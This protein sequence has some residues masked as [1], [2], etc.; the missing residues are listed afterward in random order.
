MPP[1]HT[2][3]DPFVTTTTN[4]GLRT[5]PSTTSLRST[6]SAASTSHSRTRQPQRDQ[7]FAPSLSRRPTSRTRVEDEVLADSSSEHERRSRRPRP[8]HKSRQQVVEEQ[9]IVKRD[10]QGNYLLGGSELGIGVVP[11]VKALV[12]EDE[13]EERM[14]EVNKYYSALAKKYFASG[15]AMTTTRRIDEDYER[16]RPDMMYCLKAEFI[17]KLE[18]ERWLHEPVDRLQPGIP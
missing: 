9:E 2:P 16:D 11:A 13:D 15:A 3:H 4:P 5:Q 8:Q 7:L 17:Q 1:R 10:A 14:D 18:S 6:A 12:Q